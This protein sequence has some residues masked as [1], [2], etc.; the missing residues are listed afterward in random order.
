MGDLLASVGLNRV[1][2]ASV[3]VHGANEADP[4]QGSVI[5]PILVRLHLKQQ[6]IVLRSSNSSGQASSLSSSCDLMPV[7]QLPWC[8]SSYQLKVEVVFRV[9]S[10]CREVRVSI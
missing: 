5:P 6:K 1:Q 4:V 7:K 2:E 10:L 8:G 3:R 9:C